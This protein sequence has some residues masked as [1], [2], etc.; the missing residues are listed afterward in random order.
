MKLV[1]I[2]TNKQPN[3]TLTVSTELVRDSRDFFSFMENITDGKA[4]SQPVSYVS[5][6]G[7]KPYI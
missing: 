7:G 1:R 5:K 6:H 2:T 3:D 4:F